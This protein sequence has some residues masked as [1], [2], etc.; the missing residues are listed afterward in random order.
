MPYLAW[1]FHAKRL[2]AYVIVK[3]LLLSFQSSQYT[4]RSI[5]KTQLF[6]FV[7]LQSLYN[8]DNTSFD[9]KLLSS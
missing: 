7:A 1:E 4:A 9:K 3:R 2:G 8:G 6:C 5:A